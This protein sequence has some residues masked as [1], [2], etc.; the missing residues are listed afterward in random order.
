M[1]IRRGLLI[2]G[3]LALLLVNI[4]WLAVVVFGKMYPRPA[5]CAMRPVEHVLTM[6]AQLGLTDAQVEQLRDLRRA[7]GKM[8]RPLL[9]TLRAQRLALMGELQSSGEPDSVRIEQLISRIG[10]L[11]TQLHRQSISFMIQE[12]KQL[13]E[14]QQGLFF[15][16]FENHICK[17]RRP[18]IGHKPEPGIEHR[19]GGHG[20]G[21]E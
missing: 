20:I 8:N 9:E 16:L 21:P 19:G 6:R 2:T 3:F 7:F 14:S 10:Q 15:E 17:Q 18:D 13:T 11:E 1:S 12:R 4:S 5:G